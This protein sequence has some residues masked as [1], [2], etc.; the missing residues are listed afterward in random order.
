M[1]TVKE[2][3]ETMVSDTK[4]YVINELYGHSETEQ[5]EYHY[6]LHNEIGQYCKRNS[7]ILQS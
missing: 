5:L 3:I 6:L 7:P 2:Q 4:K 1:S